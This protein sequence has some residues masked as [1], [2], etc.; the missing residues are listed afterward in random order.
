MWRKTSEGVFLFLYFYIRDKG[1][2]VRMFYLF[3]KKKDT[4]LIFL[5]K[6]VKQNKKVLK[7]CE[8]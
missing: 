3:S 1:K 2:I 8:K 7:I 4:D 6:K 5:L